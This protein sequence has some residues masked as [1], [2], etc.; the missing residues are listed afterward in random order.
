MC[1]SWRE[2]ILLTAVSMTRPS[3]LP[4]IWKRPFPRSWSLHGAAF[5]QACWAVRTELSRAWTHLILM[6]LLCSV[7]ILAWL[8][9]GRA[10]QRKEFKAASP[11]IVGDQQSSCNV[12]CMHVTKREHA[13][14]AICLSCSCLEFGLMAGRAAVLAWEEAKAA[15]P[16]ILEDHQGSYKYGGLKYEK[17]SH[18]GSASF[19]L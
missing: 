17:V 9:A 1:C 4:A 3:L 6:M 13:S 5:Y 14:D 2:R 18:P 19:E 8:M 10:L 11:C 12:G 7:A 16:T 15:N